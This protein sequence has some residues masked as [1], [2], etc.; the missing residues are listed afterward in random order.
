[1]NRSEKLRL[2][3]R[4][5]ELSID[6]ACRQLVLKEWPTLTFRVFDQESA[7][8]YAMELFREARFMVD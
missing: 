2:A 4:F 3:K 7:L 1:M 5:V 6:G 8:E